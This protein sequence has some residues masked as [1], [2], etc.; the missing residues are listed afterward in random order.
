MQDDKV[1]QVGLAEA[2]VNFTRTFSPDKPCETM[3]TEK[4]KQVFSNCEAQYW[5]VLVAHRDVHDALL[6]NM[7]RELYGL[8]KLFNGTF[9]SIVSRFSDKT[10]RQKMEQTFPQHLQNLKFDELGIDGIQFLPV[11]KSI[12]L[13]MVTLV[14][15]LEYTFSSIRYSAFLI[16]EYLVWSGLPQ[17]EIAI[18]YKYVRR[19][20]ASG[21]SGGSGFWT[22][23]ADVTKN[24][25]PINVPHIWVGAQQYF[26]VIY[27]VDDAL[28]LFVTDLAS[29]SSMTFYRD[30]EKFILKNIGN[31]SH[32][33]KGLAALNSSLSSGKSDEYRYVYFN[34]MN[35]ALKTSQRGLPREYFKLVL[36]LRRD[37]DADR[38]EIVAQCS[39][40]NWVVG[41][42]TDQRELYFVFEKK[43]SLLDVH[44]E[45]RSLSISH[46]NNI[47]V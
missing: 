1:G 37:L 31:M 15:N 25:S 7:L 42:R 22:G 45:V 17:E 26:L 23:P 46:F 36:D 41:R 5:M 43:A 38:N 6:H 34:H 9:S 33:G 47:F 10:L 20:S 35:L 8:F 13:N 4:H 11:A 30:L 40:N 2:L 16:Q 27:G 12:Y 29:S 14:N 3:T 19:L 28:L 44:E 39:D 32:A 21:N 18:L 24:D